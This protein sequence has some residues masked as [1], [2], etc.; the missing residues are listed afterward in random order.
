VSVPPAPA[1]V[2][3]PPVSQASNPP[4]EASNSLGTTSLPP[5]ATSGP[6]IQITGVTIGNAGAQSATQSTD[7]STSGPLLGST[8][9]PAAQALIDQGDAAVQTSDDL[10]AI[11][12]YQKAI[13]LAPRSATPRLKL[14]EAYVDAGMKD[15]ATEEARRALAIDPGNT[16]VQ[17]F[18]KDQDSGVDGPAG[19]VIIAQAQTESDPNNP[20]A[21]IN[22]GDAYWN[23]GDPDDSL[24]SYKRAADI[25]PTAI[26][27]Q[28]RLAKLY[29][30]RAQYDESLAAL[31]RS[32]P[33]G[34]PYA[35]RIIASRSES[36]VG[37]IDDE[38]QSFL[39]GTDTREVFY[40]KIKV[41][42][43]QAA[44]LADFVSKITPPAQYNISQ[45]H[46]QLSTS[47][48]AQTAAVWVDYAET[49]ND[50]DKVQAAELEK[51]AIEEMK[52]ASIAEDLQARINP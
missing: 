37:D 46:R 48:L 41:T 23:V 40:A 34:Y 5:N 11:S 6:T 22:L 18:I 25:D 50:S 47:L 8:I 14:A 27:P 2:T 49:N 21:W 39:K 17:N 31:R 19:D 13:S 20:T 7:T 26:L 38:T 35:L 12:L 30:A 15:Q 9:T 10:T 43:A 3:L 51:D 36:L 45:L 29:A 42:D 24:I 4:L 52:T 44:G 33:E 28:T 32:G 16:D 1:P